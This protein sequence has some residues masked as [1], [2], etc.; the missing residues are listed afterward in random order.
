[1]DAAVLRVVTSNNVDVFRLL[2]QSPLARLRVEYAVAAD[3]D[4]LIERVRAVQPDVVLV[5]AEL[6]GG[7]GY[8]ACRRIKQDPALARTHVVI[9][10]AT[11]P[12][13]R[14]HGA[15]PHVPRLSR[16]DIDLL[17]ESGADDVLALP[18]HPDDFY[19]HLAHLAGLPFRRDRRVRID[20]EIAFAS[21]EGTV[22]AQVTNAGS[23]GLGVITDA[24][25]PLQTLASARLRQGDFVSPETRLHV[26]WCRPAGDGFAAGL[27]FEGE[28][29]I[30]TRMLLEQVALFDVEPRDGG[31]VTVT[32]HGDFTELTRFEGLTARL[33]DEDDLEF[34]TASV[35]YLSS[36][37]VRA[38]C[39]FLAGQAG[40]RYRF[41]HCSVAF[42]SQA[43]MVPMVLG[44]GEVVSLEA[45]YVC[46][47]CDTEDMRLLDVQA[48]AQDGG[49]LPPRLTCLACGGE[50]SFDDVP[51]R[52]F[53]FL[54]D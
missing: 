49:P 47:Q 50:L 26:A 43:A 45:P 17:W 48:I 9:L 13:A 42:A 19:H 34:D 41:R 3:Q 20:L 30:K 35:R 32:L 31:G 10:L 54:A 44:E 25:L 15:P 52:Y 51:E 4:E 23:G 16:A 28:P 11:P 27:R 40:K 46:E 5:D 2:G 21:D 37:G 14:P 24:P 53:A 33:T 38:W 12:Q 39:E 29:P 1:M 36:A 8:D 22:V 18:V 7:S 6:A